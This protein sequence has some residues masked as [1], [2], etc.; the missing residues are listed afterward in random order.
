MMYIPFSHATNVGGPATFMRNLKTYFDKVGYDTTEDLVQAEGIFFPISFDTA[1]LNQF[2]GKGQRIIQRLD[3]ICYPTKH[4]E[5]YIGINEPIKEI[6]TDY[7]TDIVFQSKYSQAQVTTMFGDCKKFSIITNGVDKAVFYPSSTK[8][9]ELAGI[10]NFITTG[11]IRN[12]DMIEPVIL[13]LDELA[14][15]MRF[16]F[17]VVG[18]IKDELKSFL[19]RPYVNYLGTK[20]LFEVAELLRQADIFIYSHLNPPCP[21]SVL[22][23]ISSGL[24]VVG[25][26]SGAMA[27][28]LPFSTEL[29]APVSEDIF[30]VYKDFSPG[31]LKKKLETSVADFQKYKLIALEGSKLYGFEQCG[32]NYLKVFRA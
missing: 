1:V 20:N 9:T 2:K 29:L 4:G 32:E 14:K 26:D 18:P 7:A 23:A 19:D 13:A 11:N 10:P 17:T 21:N 6:Y 22:E 24:P 28:L 8:S 31:E 30:Q 27:E 25:F 16:V 12:L 3:G 5:A 15:T